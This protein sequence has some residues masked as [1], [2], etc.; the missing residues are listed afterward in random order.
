MHIVHT[1]VPRVADGEPIEKASTIAPT[2]VCGEFLN[3]AVIGVGKVRCSVI[4]TYSELLFKLLRVTNI[5]RGNEISTG[6]G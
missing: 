4:A 3:H 2:P 5:A 6:I 1:I